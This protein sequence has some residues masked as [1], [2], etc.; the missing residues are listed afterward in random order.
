MEYA[1]LPCASSAI[2]LEKPAEMSSWSAISGGM[3]PKL[4]NDAAADAGAAEACGLLDF[5]FDRGSKA[6][7][8]PL[9]AVA[10]CVGWAELQRGCTS[11]AYHA[12]DFAKGIS[13][14]VQTWWR[15]RQNSVLQN[16]SR[17][18]Q[19]LQPQAKH[20]Y[21]QSMDLIKPHRQVMRP[22]PHLHSTSQALALS[23]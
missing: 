23:C 8:F 18:L 11:Y 13:Q 12:P 2:I 3:A 20:S 6:R 10:G 22:V 4:P 19:P 17:H 21:Q 16:R 5:G 14:V 15:Q 7:P 9:L 1:R